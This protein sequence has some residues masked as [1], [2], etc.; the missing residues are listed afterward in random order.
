MRP[1]LALALALTLAAPARAQDTA[2]SIQAR[3]DDDNIAPLSSTSSAPILLARPILPQQ[4]DKIVG[5]PHAVLK[6][7]GMFPAIM[8]GTPPPKRYPGFWGRHRVPFEDSD[9]TLTN[10]LDISDATPRFRA[11]AFERILIGQSKATIS[12]IATRKGDTWG[13]NGSA[14]LVST[15][16]NRLAADNLWL[17][18]KPTGVDLWFRFSDGIERRFTFK[19]PADSPTCRFVGLVD[20]D[21]A[22]VGAYL[23]GVFTLPTVAPDWA[24]ASGLTFAVPEFPDFRMGTDPIVGQASVIL[25]GFRIRSGAGGLGGKLDVPPGT[26]W[27]LSDARTFGPSTSGYDVWLDLATPLASPDD[28]LLRYGRGSAKYGYGLLTPA[29]AYLPGVPVPVQG[30]DVWDTVGEIEV[31]DLTIVNGDPE[32]GSGIEAG[33]VR[34]LKVTNVEIQGGARGI[35][36]HEKAVSYPVWLSGVRTVNQREV[37]I[38]LGRGICYLDSVNCGAGPRRAHIRIH[39]AGGKFSRLFLAETTQPVSID[40]KNFM[41]SLAIADSTINFEA[42]A[43]DAFIRLRREKA[44]GHKALLSLDHVEL[45]GRAPKVAAIDLLDPYWKGRVDGTVP[46]A[47]VVIRESLNVLDRKANLFK[48][49]SG[50][51]VAGNDGKTITADGPIVAPAPNPVPAPTPTPAD[52]PAVVPS[53]P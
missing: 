24:A 32:H 6:T 19:R 34:N 27:T 12:F 52:P 25:G 20:L 43:P 45:G 16:S 50:A 7:Q 53:A 39:S 40:V 13:Q 28:P 5:F 2:A 22:K 31:R 36:F 4:D 21:A 10:G 42:F 41:S 17:R 9:G 38:G 23:D 14:V 8:P 30:W 35:D 47:E 1:L 51:W 26:P 29:T 18:V 11:S 46:A 49:L 33:I 37:A 48:G 15:D 44:D 3:L